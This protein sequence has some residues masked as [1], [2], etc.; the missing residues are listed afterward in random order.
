VGFFDQVLSDLAIEAWK[1]DAQIHF[2]AKSSR[3][4]ANAYDGHDSRVLR[5]S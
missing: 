4:W 5:E 1:R 2:K 3:D